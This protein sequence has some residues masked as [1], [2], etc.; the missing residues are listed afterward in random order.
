MAT[1]GSV[2]GQ[3]GGNFSNREFRLTEISLSEIIR[4]A[5]GMDALGLERAPGLAQG[6]TGGDLESGVGVRRRPVRPTSE[7][8]TTDGSEARCASQDR[9]VRVVLH[10]D[11]DLIEVRAWPIA[12]RFIN[13]RPLCATPQK[14]LRT[15]VVPF[16]P[17][18]G[19]G[20]MERFRARC[21]KLRD[22]GKADHVA[23]PVAAAAA[24]A[25]IL[26]DMENKFLY[27]D[28]RA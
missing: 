26:E 28:P 1:A 13:R 3:V 8:Q 18:K 20:A 6:E 19:I 7:R 27:S 11:K 21:G 23:L 15:V 9:R 10:R 17:R 4:H 22:S 14:K 25:D 5:N 2:V 24:M 12:A 16:D